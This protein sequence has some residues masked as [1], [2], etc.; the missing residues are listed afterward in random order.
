[1][2]GVGLVALVILCFAAGY[3]IVTSVFAAFERKTQGGTPASRGGD[4]MVESPAEHLRAVLALRPGATMEELEDAHRTHRD[5]YA[6]LA[7]TERDPEIRELARQK[8]AAI[9]EAYQYFLRNPSRL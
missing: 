6:T 8:A 4:L 3:I 7:E 5:R 1:L 9:E 2:S